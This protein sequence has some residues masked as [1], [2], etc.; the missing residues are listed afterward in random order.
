MELILLYRLRYSTLCLIVPDMLILDMS[1]MRMSMV[2]QIK[3]PNYPGAFISDYAQ[4]HTLNMDVNKV[5]DTARNSD[6]VKFWRKHKST[7]GARSVVKVFQSMSALHGKRNV[8]DMWMLQ[9][10]RVHNNALREV[11][12]NE[13][14]FL[15]FDEW[16]ATAALPDHT[17]G[18]HYGGDALKMNVMI[19]LNMLCSNKNK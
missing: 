14:G 15:D 6:V 4:V 17:D 11:F 2:S 3:P 1:S 7:L 8:G 10:F 5:L 13:L 12:I 18:W 16:I 9:P 19:L